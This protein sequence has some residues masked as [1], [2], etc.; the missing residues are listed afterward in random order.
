WA[1][2]DSLEVWAP[3]HAW[4]T[5]G[6]L[7]A[8]A[9]IEPLLPLFE[10]AEDDDWVMEELPDVIGMIGP[11][12]IPAVTAY[13]ADESHPIWARICASRCLVEI[14]KMHPEVRDECVAALAGQLERFEENDLEMNGFLV[15]HLIDLK[16]VEAA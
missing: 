6:Q 8:E 5:L 2:S 12:A 14:G 11:T 16:A 7:R 3:I 13:V 9:A 1:D 15:S 4:R 10:E